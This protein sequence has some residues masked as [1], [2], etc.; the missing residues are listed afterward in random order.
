MAE[1][2]GERRAVWRA[3][4]ELFLDLDVADVLPG[5]EAV[6]RASPYSADDLEQIML[7]EV[8]PVCHWN[9]RSVAGEW[10]GFDRDWLVE[11]CADRA[12]LP[13][14]RRALLRGLHRRGL[15]RLVPE[16]AEVLKALR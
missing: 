13:G 4:S 16:W 9:L 6:L 14:W 7:D 1:C 10:T 5:V 2:D 11:R 8:Y 3:L 12:A 15:N